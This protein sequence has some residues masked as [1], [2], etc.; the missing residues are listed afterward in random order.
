VANQAKPP[1]RI[2]IVAGTFDEF[3]GV[4]ARKLQEYRSDPTLY[5][6]PELR[7]VW[8]TEVLRGLSNIEGFYYGSYEQRPDIDEIRQLIATIKSRKQVPWKL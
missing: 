7:Y 4:Q 8:S 1:K 3:K 6:Y 2:Y 5:V